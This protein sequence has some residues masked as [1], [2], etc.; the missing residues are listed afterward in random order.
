MFFA[1][2]NLSSQALER[3]AAPWDFKPEPQDAIPEECK[4]DKK[5]RDSWINMPSTKWC[6]YTAHEAVN[7][8]MRISKARSDGDGNPVLACWALV[9][10]YDAKATLEEVKRFMENLPFKPNWVERTL[11]G[12]WRFV[13]ILEEKLQFPSY[14]FAVHFYENFATYAFDPNRGMMGFDNPAFCEPNRLWTNSGEWYHIGDAKIPA[15]ISRGWLVAASRTF[16][17]WTAEGPSI[18]LEEVHKALVAKY[19]KIQE[20]PTEF[21]LESQGPTFWIEGSTSPKSAIV[22]ESGIQ[23]FSAHAPKAFYNWADLLGIQFVKQYEA[24]ALG[25][26]VADVWFNGKHYYMRGADNIWNARERTDCAQHLKIDRKVSTKAAKDGT[27]PLEE[28]MCYIRNHHKVVDAL[29]FVMQPSGLLVKNG[30]RVLNISDA[31]VKTPAEGKQEWGPN[32]NFPWISAFIEHLFPKL[33]A[34]ER[35]LA[36]AARAYRGAYLLQPESGHAL[37]IAGGV[38]VGKT[39]FS[40]SILAPLFG[41]LAE[42][43]SYLLGETTFNSELFLRYYWAVDDSEPTS[44]P[45]KVARWTSS[46]KRCVA[47]GS[48]H[49]NEKFK[50]AG[51]TEWLGRLVVTLNA[52][53]ESIRIIP[54]MRSSIED[55]LIIVR[56]TD[57]K[58][59]FPKRYVLDKILAAELPFFARWLLDHCPEELGRF[60]MEEYADED[61]VEAASQSGN[62][63]NFYEVLH[64]WKCEYFKANPKE[65]SWSGTAFQFHKE[66]TNDPR[67]AIVLKGLTTK[68]IT[69]SFGEMLEKKFVGLSHSTDEAT[70]QAIWTIKK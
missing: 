53:R 10:D 40:R 9:M 57:T 13:F 65:T 33:A 6:V 3:L 7:P 22:R 43:A 68:A 48:W 66:L 12:H 62:L 30:N 21:T 44:S 8:N 31:R 36:W 35:V 20:W 29:P 37:F 56:T 69:R 61:I 27:S 25:R 2:K 15:D 4:I 19:P 5:A 24:E 60:G 34:R 63:N 70:K 50:A 42:A 54:D 41:G 11:S 26:A 17:K 58:F 1:L 18:P 47:N 64:D 16:K 32:G 67:N 55:K 39:L 23:T 52:D 46:V 14:D 49:F 28:A 45:E 51:Q 59:N 38:G